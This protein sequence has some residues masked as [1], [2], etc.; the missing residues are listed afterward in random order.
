MGWYRSVPIKARIMRGEKEQVNA[1]DHPASFK[2]FE[3]CKDD[4]LSC[5]LIVNWCL[6]QNEKDADQIVAITE[7]S[8]K[9]VITYPSFHWN[10]TIRFFCTEAG[11]P[12]EEHREVFQTYFSKLLPHKIFLISNAKVG[13]DVLV[14]KFVN[15]W[16]VSFNLRLLSASI[17]WSHSI[18]NLIWRASLLYRLWRWIR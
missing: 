6:V 1:V 5:G 10:A 8:E 17:S 3:N 16:G 4:H 13:I 2:G 14:V 7:Q 11:D 18:I 15:R 12:C 9:Q